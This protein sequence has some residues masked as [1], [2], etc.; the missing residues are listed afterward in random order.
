MKMNARKFKAWD[1]KRKKMCRIA[2]IDFEK[3]TV[4]LADNLQFKNKRA[5]PFGQVVFLEGSG[6]K[7]VRGREAFEGDIIW[8]ELVGPAIVCKDKVKITD[9]DPWYDNYLEH[10]EQ[11]IIC[12]RSILRDK[13]W[14]F[15]ELI[16]DSFEILGNKYENRS[17]IKK[18]RKDPYGCYEGGKRA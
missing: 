9:D 11:K 14:G 3:K 16:P 13:G 1:K 8:V 5:V 12:M 7:D 4:V 10:H 18:L 15:P 17:L 6:K 2:R